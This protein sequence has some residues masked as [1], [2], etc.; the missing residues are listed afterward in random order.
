MGSYTPQTS[1][2]LASGIIALARG[3]KGTVSV[4][5]VVAFG[6]GG[7]TWIGRGVD[8]EGDVDDSFEWTVGY[9]LIREGNKFSPHP[10]APFKG[11]RQGAEHHA[12]QRMQFEATE[13]PLNVEISCNCPIEV[14][15]S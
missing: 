1:K 7:L 2:Q 8:A 6:K 15:F 9:S 12:I 3:E 11:E 4:E 5:G 10:Q 14:T 13:G